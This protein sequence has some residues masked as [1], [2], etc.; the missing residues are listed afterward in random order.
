MPASG[1][2]EAVC[3]RCGGS[4]WILQPDGG[5]GAAR[6]C[7]CRETELL[8]R[9]LAAARIP[10][11]YQP[12]TLAGF[13]DAW[14]RNNRDP[15]LESRMRGILVGARA[16]CQQYID[17]FL[18][19]DGRFTDKGLLLVGPTGVGKTHLAAAVLSELIRRYR[20]RGLFAD[21]T[22]LIHEIQATF[23][24]S[25][26]D[27][28]QDVLEPVMEAELLVLDELGAQK[29]T[30]WVSETLYLILNHRYTQ[31]R[32]TLFTTNCRLEPES[33]AEGSLDGP[34]RIEDRH[35][36]SHRVSAA[37][38][39]RLYEMARVVSVELADDFRRE[40]KAAQHRN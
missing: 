30:A 20:V 2:A 12:C 35:P 37:L 26:A 32:P 25:S 24:P 9:L 19:E 14:V 36:L 5:A 40:V 18:G 34:G 8:P 38:V 4:G 6:A 22:A 10:P 33:G 29:P 23:D 28:K 17:G 16:I 11:R 31:K 39:S 13:Q 7:E 15:H 1:G 21:F 3:A 27:S